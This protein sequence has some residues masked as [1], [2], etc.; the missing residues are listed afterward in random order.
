[1]RFLL[2]ENLPPSFANIL[3]K[4]GFEARHV[5]DVGLGNVP[6]EE[7]VDFAKQNGDTIITN[8]FDFSRIMAI[9]KHPLPSVITFR[10]PL[11]FETFEEIC[12]LNFRQFEAITND[13]C[14]ITIDENGIRIRNL[15]IYR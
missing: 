5:Y 13:G 15:P 2:D 4:I 14:L 7:I 9:S 8:D 6:D 1:M 12:T 10:M 3:R 11:N